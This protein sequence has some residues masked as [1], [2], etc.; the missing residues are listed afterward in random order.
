MR[1][2]TH[3]RLF[4]PW[5]QAWL[6]RAIVP[7]RRFSIVGRGVIAVW[8]GVSSVAMASVSEATAEDEQSQSAA[9][10]KS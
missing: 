3:L 9:T 1:T 5:F 4:A 2:F 10:T 8:L 6:L 7:R